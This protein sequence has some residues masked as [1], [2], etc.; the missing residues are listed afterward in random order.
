M[1]IKTPLTELK[2]SV[3]AQETPIS[4]FLTASG[5]FCDGDLLLN[6][7]GLRLMSDEK[8]SRPS[9]GKELDFEIT[10]ADL[11]SVKVIG[12]GNGG[13]VQLVR[14]KWDGKLFAMK[15]IQM[16]IQEEIRKQIVQ[17]L[18][19]NQASQCP[20][21]VVC[22]QS[23]Y[24]N[25]A[26]S[27]VLEYMDRGSLADVIKQVK[28]ILEP[29]LAVAC[30]QVLQGLVYLHNERH[31]IHRDIKPSNLLVNHKGEVKISD[32]GVSAS[33]ASSMG[34]R[35]TFVGTYNYMSPERISGSTYEYSSD[36]WSLGLSVLECAIGRFPYL[37]SEDQENSP[38]FYELLA[39]IVESPPPTAPP[40][41]FSPEFC[42]FVSACIQKDPRDR[43]SSL[44]LL[45]H[46]FI[47]K[48]E[49]KDIDLG[50]LVGSLEPPVNYPR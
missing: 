5:T 16:N 40:N 24:H 2:L 1:K 8:E 31:V 43:S 10:P 50:I 30:K 27:L 17:E 21:V 6:Q 26:F 47:K 32:F 29:Y 44:D 33:L 34:Q 45:R 4:S 42:S 39:A 18:I 36:I 14:H 25:G 20:H 46:P 9:E 35:D 3:P 12:K 41:Q 28:T 38:S 49:D 23:F 19:I 11:E 22:Y 7:K 48:F 15:V 37:Q 13:V